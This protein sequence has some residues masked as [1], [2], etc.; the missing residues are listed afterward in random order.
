MAAG[1]L[2]PGARPPRSRAEALAQRRAQLAH[3]LGGRFWLRWHGSVLVSATFAVGFAANAAMLWIPVH[4][5]LVRWPLAV[6]AGYLAFFLLVRL[7]LAYVGVRPFGSDARQFDDGGVI[8][9]LPLDTG[10][11]VGRGG[12]SVFAGGGGRSGGGGAS[13]L[14][15]APGASASSGGSAIAD[16]GFSV[17]D[18]VGDADGCLPVVLGL[19][20][21]A[22]V[23]ALLGGAVWLVWIAP[24]FLTDA[25]FGAMLASGVLPGIRRLDEA[26]WGGRILKATWPAF[27][28]ALVVVL[29]A[30]AAFTHYFPGLRTLGEAFMALR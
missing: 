23:V 4:S 15:D 6:F 19:V 20:I 8:A 2:A 17:G 24:Q 21:L 22:I 27:A 3:T 16:G 7:W 11:A 28:I 5:V 1:G 13:A 30:G 10:G 14:F 26:D 9:N 29:L 25:A 18:A 12:S